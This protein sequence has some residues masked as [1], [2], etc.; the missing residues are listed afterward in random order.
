MM[1]LQEI[2]ERTRA[3]EKVGIT[4]RQ[5]L[6]LFGS[7]GRGWRVVG[8]IEK[9]L[10]ELGLGT[11]PSFEPPTKLDATVW[12]VVRPTEAEIATVL[13]EYTRETGHL[14]GSKRLTPKKDDPPSPPSF[15]AVDVE[16]ANP[17]RDSICQ[18]GI[19]NVRDGQIVDEWTTL[20][21][22]ETWFDDWNVDIHGID[23][24]DVVGSPTMPELEAE[25]RQRLQD[26]VVSHSAFDRVAFQRAFKR[27]GLATLSGVWV[28]TARV[29][30]RAWRDRFGKKGYGL[31]N[32][33]EFLGIEFEHHDALEDARACARIMLRACQDTGLSLEDWP[34]RVRQPIFPSAHGPGPAPGYRSREGNPDGPLH[35][36]V[37]VFTGTLLRPRSELV[38]KAVEWGCDYRNRMSGRVT[39]LVVGTQDERKLRGRKKSTKQRDAEA[40]ITK[41][42]E[43]RIITEEDFWQLTE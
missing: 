5:L 38:D 34:K 41:G 3:G 14:P 23:E 16:T 28:D 13:D 24:E 10:Q 35:G 31:W 42:H 12:F 27:H 39:I 21:D 43:L 17:S 29:V 25:I 37:I 30:R 11:E 15:S 9:E 1:E 40:L 20:V 36:E 19:V 6:R 18:V 22:P 7:K 2:V 26:H 32:V 4:V 8:R 33:A